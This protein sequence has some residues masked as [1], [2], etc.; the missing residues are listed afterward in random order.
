MAYFRWGA[1][2]ESWV[3]GLGLGNQILIAVALALLLFLIH[4]VK[5]VAAAVSSFAG[6]GVGLA[7]MRRYVPFS[8]SGPPSPGDFP[9][10]GGG[11]GGVGLSPS[12]SG[13]C[14]TGWSVCGRRWE[15]PGCS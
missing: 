2:I 5:D 10:S 6:L 12:R 3:L 15:L 8:T 7:L 13:C 11:G 4:P 9:L 14:A 1:R